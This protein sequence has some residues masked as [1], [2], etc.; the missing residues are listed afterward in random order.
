MCE[1]YSTIFRRY[2][3]PFSFI[4]IVD[5]EQVNVSWALAFTTV[6]IIKA[7]SNIQGIFSS[8]LTKSI[9][10]Y[11]IMSFFLLVKWI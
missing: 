10:S 5:F 11:E 2:F 3:T 8:L 7:N 1:I 9:V 6:I 4:F